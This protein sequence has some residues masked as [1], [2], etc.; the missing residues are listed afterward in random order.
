MIVAHVEE[1]LAAQEAARVAL[2]GELSSMKP[3]AVYRKAQ[4]LGVDKHRLDGAKDKAAIVALIVE[5]SLAEVI[6]GTDPEP[7]PAAE[8]EPE[9]PLALDLLIVVGRGYPNSSGTVHVGL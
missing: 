9:P 5:L 7:E 8:P 3:R 6:G 1:Q 2:L 4:Q